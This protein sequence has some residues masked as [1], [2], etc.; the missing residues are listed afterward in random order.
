MDAAKQWY[1]QQ[2]H[3]KQ[4]EWKREQDL[5]DVIK[6]YKELMETNES[7]INVNM[8]ITKEKVEVKKELQ[9]T[10]KVKIQQ[11]ELVY[12]YCKLEKVNKNEFETKQNK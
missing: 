9:L 2:A 8:K 11:H 12:K 4:Q 1:K 7:A 5:W 3:Q 10:K 6:Q